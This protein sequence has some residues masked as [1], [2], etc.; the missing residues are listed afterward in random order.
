MVTWAVKTVTYTDV[1]MWRNL[2]ARDGVR[3]FEGK[4]PIIWLRLEVD[5]EPVGCAGILRQGKKVTIRGRWIRPEYR[6]Q[7]W[8][9]KLAEARMRYIEKMPGVERVEGAAL[10]TKH[11]ARLGMVAEGPVMKVGAQKMVKHLRPSPE[12]SLAIAIMHAPWVPER[13]A[14]VMA[15][16]RELGGRATVIADTRRQGVW[17]TARRTWLR[18]AGQSTSHALLLQDDMKLAPGF[19]RGIDALVQA[20]P[21]HPISGFN[22]NVAYF[23]KAEAAGGRWFRAHGVY[24]MIIVLPHAWIEPF[25][26]WADEWVRPD[27]IHD[28]RRLSMFCRVHERYVWTTVPALGWHQGEGHSLLGHNEPHAKEPPVCTDV[29]AV[30]WTAGVREPPLAA[31]TWSTQRGWEAMAKDASVAYQDTCLADFRG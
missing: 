8:G 7:G 12:V 13:R 21:D 22:R 15:Q 1:E 19:G 27:F 25:V 2:A 4:T 20:C 30:D 5:G 26:H 29:S 23:K 14:W 6:G 18:L 3:L 24:G 11:L 9:W 17:P 10:E 28:D 16:Q 31:P